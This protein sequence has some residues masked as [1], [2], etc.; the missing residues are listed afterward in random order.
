MKTLIYGGRIVND[1]RVYDASLVIENDV[2]AEIKEPK[3]PVATTTRRWMPQG[4]LSC[5]E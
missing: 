1:G 4:F 5:Q 3:Y 2:I